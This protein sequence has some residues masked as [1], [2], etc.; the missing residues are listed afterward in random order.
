M[1]T[2]AKRRPLWR[3]MAEVLDE[4]PL[5]LGSILSTIAYLVLDIWMRAL[6]GQVM[7]AASGGLFWSKL[8]LLVAAPLAAAPF[9][10]ISMLT[11]FRMSELVNM[12][13]RIRIGEKSGRLSIPALEEQRSGDIMSHLGDELNSIYSF[14]GSGLSTITTLATIILCTAWFMVIIDLPLTAILMGVSLLVLPF[15]LRITKPIRKNEESKRNALGRA[16]Q[17]AQEGLSSPV[18]IKSFRLEKLVNERYQISLKEAMRADMRSQRATVQ[19]TAGGTAL[20]MVPMV[21][22]LVL[23]ALRVAQG[24]LSAG[25]LLSL[26]MVGYGLVYWLTQ[27]PNV[28]SIVQRALGAC[29]RIYDYLDLPEEQGGLFSQ[30]DDSG[31]V[32]AFENVTFGYPDNPPLLKS[33]SFHVRRGETVALVGASGCGKSTILK[34]ICG[35]LEADSGEVRVMGGAVN[36]WALGPL[37]GQL[38]LV[39]QDSYLFP[40]SIRDNL[41]AA[42]NKATDEQLLLACERAGILAF[43]TERGLDA[44]VGERGIQVSGGE[45]QRLSIARAMLKDAPVLLLDEPTSALDAAAERIV[46]QSMER[47]MEGRTT[48]VVAHRLS[49]IRHADR[50][51]VIQDGA[52]VTQGT[53]DHLIRESPLYRSLYQQQ[54][55]E[56]DGV[57]I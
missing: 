17:M 53:H 4:W 23:G 39:S 57:A 8:W 44:Q 6:T 55:L 1:K 37:R 7:D 24:T 2:K 32:I 12:K 46:Q 43:V 15:S 48:L 35:F 5:Y 30:P 31:D 13:L 14:A 49:T 56:R 16:Q 34:L 29:T 54:M 10:T 22:M 19:M 27:V 42:N 26:T 18:V 9:H 45:R 28:F 47:L 51:L 38:A 50:I 3:L 36:A 21:V 20:G 52:I 25:Q 33:I 40:G 11:K 41:L